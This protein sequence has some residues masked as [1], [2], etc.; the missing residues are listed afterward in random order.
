MIDAVVGGQFGS[1]GKGLV[2]GEIAKRYG[3]HVR[4]GA[5]NAGHTVY[6]DGEKHVVQ[7]IPVAAYANP[8]AMLILGPGALISMEILVA[9]INRNVAWR[10]ANGHGDLRLI[11]DPRAHVITDEHIEA[12]ANTDLAE[13][14]G[15]TSTISKEGIGTATAARVMRQENCLRMGDLT[16]DPATGVEVRD[17]IEFIDAY[18]GDVGKHVLLEGTQGTGLSLTTGDFPYV[19][20]R[21]PTASGLAADAGIGPRDIT[22]VIMVL[23]TFPIRVAGKSGPFGPGSQELTFDEIGVPPEKTTV[24]KLQRRIATFSMLQA[25]Q[26]ALIN[27]ANRVVLTF[28]DYIAPSIANKTKL[29]ESDG[30]DY[31]VGRLMGMTQRIEVATRTTVI[32]V[33]TGPA[34]M[35]D[36][37]LGGNMVARDAILDRVEKDRATVQS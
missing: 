12:E 26:A 22:N 33:G 19:T 28:G 30:D 27:S 34:S 15:S 9:E 10:Q 7:S 1:E 21:N 31:R 35:I 18:R 14:I 6:V 11:I 2:V 32:G 13:R 23:R 36:L 3:V 37:G 5:S 24:T 25:Q 20:S 29:E 4:V 16:I 17:T 8:D